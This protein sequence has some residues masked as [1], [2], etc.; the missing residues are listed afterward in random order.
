MCDT[1]GAWD[2]TLVVVVLSDCNVSGT[3][4]HTVAVTWSCVQELTC[5]RVGYSACCCNTIVSLLMNYLAMRDHR[6]GLE[7]QEGFLGS[8]I[9]HADGTYF[10]IIW[11][12][13]SDQRDMFSLNH[14]IFVL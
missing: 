11:T 13:V 6:F 14:G 7:N 9:S 5:Y 2:D 10:M 1:W 12:L 4:D 3:L 8:G